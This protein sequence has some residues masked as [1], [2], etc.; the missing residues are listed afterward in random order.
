MDLRSVEWRFTGVIRTLALVKISFGFV[1]IIAIIKALVLGT[2]PSLLIYSVHVVTFGIAALW[3]HTSKQGDRAAHNLGMVFLLAA[4]AF[5]EPVILNSRQS[6]FMP[7]ETADLLLTLEPESWIPF[8]LAAFVAEFPK[9]R[10]TELP[11]IFRSLKTL[12][13]YL[14]CVLFVINLLPIVVEVGR[15]H[16]LLAKLL[17]P[18]AGEPTYFWTILMTACVPSAVLAVWKNRIAAP[19]ERRRASFFANGL[20]LGIAPLLLHLLGEGLLTGYSRFM[21]VP[22]HERNAQ[23]I[24]YPA[25]LSIP[26]T[27][28]YCV[29]VHRVFDLRL[30][31]RRALQYAFARY[32]VLTIAAV[33]LL[34]TIGYLYIH[35]TEPIG[36]IL[37]G[38]GT[39]ILPSAA[40]LGLIAYRF[41]ERILTTI[42]RR[43]FREQYDATAILAKL[44]EKARGVEAAGHLVDLTQT[45]IDRALH[46]DSIHFFLLE[47]SRHRF[48]SARDSIRALHATSAVT[49]MLQSQSSCILVDP[50]DPE[51]IFSRLPAEDQEWIREGAFT[52]LVPMIAGNHDLIGVIALGEKKSRLGYS[53]EDKSFLIDMAGSAALAIENQ[54]L[55][56]STPSQL[57]EESPV[58]T[59]LNDLDE[60]A[61]CCSLCAAIQDREQSV[62][63]RCG[64]AVR[65]VN[66]PYVIAGKFQVERK[67]GSGGMGVVYRAVDLT[68]RRAVA[69]KTLPQVSPEY[70]LRLRQEAQA[71]AAITHPNLATIYTAE[72]WRGTPILIF[73]YLAGGTL[74]DRLHRERLSISESLRI[75]I[76][77][78]DALAAIHRARILHRDVKPSNIGFTSDGVAKLL[79]FGLAKLIG[80]IPNEANPYVTPSADGFAVREPLSET[81]R[82][83]STA[84]MVGTPAYLSPEIIRGSDADVYADLWSLSLTLYEAITGHNPVAGPTLQE[85]FRRIRTV[86]VPDVR[87][88]V[89]GCPEV[90]S[91]LFKEALHQ[92]KDR[93]PSTAK[94]LELRLQAIAT[95]VA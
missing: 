53:P 38:S 50:E 56:S 58:I 70:A 5:A 34:V 93:R 1:A 16:P 51:S 63:A 46:I 43:F 85:T 74:S 47:T 89:P 57:R 18:D 2:V 60:V 59:N 15:V 83:S 40:L 91:E 92:D 13:W 42:D 73:E 36:A 14:G 7:G 20:L 66:I 8:F 95:A 23:L 82:E 65:A 72:T 69:V 9:V 78:C 4:S 35:R 26:I 11:R 21:S 29:L 71:V 76:A 37:S 6:I 12:T 17:D 52:L 84:Y 55:R 90:L 68:L 80:Q 79:D 86:A 61:F 44:I 24:V 10:F 27:T 54:V 31:M 49:Q 45:E 28:A 30:L 33:P 41:R 81:M 62:C 88:F 87:H 19:V 3:L 75:G 22:Q 77:L 39:P 48:R 25:F 67:I 94:E 64:G 32:A